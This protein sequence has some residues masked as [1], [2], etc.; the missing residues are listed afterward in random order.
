MKAL[1]THKTRQRGGALIMVLLLAATLSFIVLGLA[2][3]MTVSIERT[4]GEAAR[5]EL[6]W[7]MMS[8]ETLARAAIRE[9]E[10]QSE[11]AGVG[12]T[13]DHPLFARAFET[14]M[15]NGSGAIRFA[16]ATRCFNLNSLVRAQSAGGRLNEDAVKEFM[17][18]GEAVGLS[19]SEAENIAHVVADWI[20]TDNIQEIGG[21]E[22]GLYM[23]LPTP[24]RTGSTLLASVSE[25]RAMDGVAAELYLALKPYLCAHPTHESSRINVNMLRPQ[26]APLL[27]GLTGGALSR[28]EAEEVIADRPP[29]G[30]KSVEAFWALPA[31]AKA[32][33]E[34]EI[35]QARTAVASRFLE[36]RGWGSVN[37]I[38]IAVSLFFL[39]DTQSGE[40]ELISREIGAAS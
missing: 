25:L 6:I 31:L 24:F 37:E 30:W 4:S 15:E 27:S 7:R 40:I 36:V 26:D 29:G 13:L 39:T 22:D 18:I 17:E 9:A 21:G 35:Q 12:F 5:G 38:D 10:K 14:P 11:T 20:D 28:L 32:E 33:I 8:L 23:A 3:R 19:A 34:A 2:Q 1:Q 16:D